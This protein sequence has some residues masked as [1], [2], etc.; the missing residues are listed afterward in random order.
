MLSKETR[1]RRAKYVYDQSVSNIEQTFKYGKDILD[2]KYKLYV[3]SRQPDIALNVLHRIG[4]AKLRK[5]REQRDERIGRAARM[6]EKK[7]ALIG[8]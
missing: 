8:K 7:V 3:K 5:L 4:F 1:L 2:K 6:L